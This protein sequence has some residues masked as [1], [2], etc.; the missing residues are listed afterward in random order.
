M[1]L[2]LSLYG[3]IVKKMFIA[4]YVW[5]QLIVLCP[6]RWTYIKGLYRYGKHWNLSNDDWDHLREVLK[7][8]YYLIVT[9]RSTHLST[10]LQQIASLILQQKWTRWTH[11]FL[12]MDNGEAK[13]D[14]QYIFLESTA[15]GVHYSTFKQVFDCDSVGLIVPKG[16]T[17]QDWTQIIETAIAQDGKPYDALFDY[18]QD[19]AFSCIELVRKALMGLPDYMTRFAK[20]EAMIQKEGHVLPQMLAECPDFEVVWQVRR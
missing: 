17:P 4:F 10:Y 20:F 8:H 15:Q 9:Y 14:I 11:A 1:A 18:H 3:G 13:D 19:Y 2:P 6:I 7:P 5:L 16:M 12:N